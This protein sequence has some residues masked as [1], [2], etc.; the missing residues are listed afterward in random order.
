MHL[1]VSNVS[2]SLP[3]VQNHVSSLLGDQAAEGPRT[4]RFRR[5]GLFLY[6]LNPA[7]VSR[8]KSAECRHQFRSKWLLGILSEK[9]F[10]F[11]DGSFAKLWATF[12]NSNSTLAPLR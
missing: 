2:H 10:R 11:M 7:W 9:T 4:R 6:R 8:R 1:P 5:A 3:Q 12:R